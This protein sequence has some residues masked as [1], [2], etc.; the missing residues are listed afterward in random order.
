MTVPLTVEI[1]KDSA[2][3]E[4]DISLPRLGVR[5]VAELSKGAFM[6]TAGTSDTL[7]VRPDSPVISLDDTYDHIPKPGDFRIL[8]TGRKLEIPSLTTPLGYAQ[9]V[10]EH[11]GGIAVVS[12]YDC[13]EGNVAAVTAHELGHL[14]HL[15]YDEGSDHCE[16]PTCLMH[17]TAQ[18]SSARH[19]EA[20]EGTRILNNRYCQPCEV[21][22]G[23]RALRL[24]YQKKSELLTSANL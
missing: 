5:Y 8:L 18:Y 15:S 10:N 23:R 24:M 1:V 6:L 9:Y 4:V 17:H 11:S 16:N 20:P 13:N 12:T 14:F 2:T 7:T 22:I 19:L 21:Q 3:P